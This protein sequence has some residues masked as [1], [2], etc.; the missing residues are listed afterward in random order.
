VKVLYVLGNYPKISETYV[1][2]EITFMLQRGVD[3]EVWSKREGTPGMEAQVP[4]HR[5]A[6]LSALRE[7]KPDLVHVHYLI[8]GDAEILAA[9]AEGV[10]VTIRG[11]SY[12][13]T[14][15]NVR[16]RLKC[17][18][19]QRIYLFPHFCTLF[20][21]DRRVMP[22]PVAYDGDRYSFLPPSQKDHH[23]VLRTCAAKPTKGIAD[24]L[25]VSALCPE[26]RFVLLANT[27]GDGWV[28]TL[29]EMVKTIGRVELRED[30]PNEVA[31]MWT[32]RAGIYLDTNDPKGHSFGMPISVVESMATGAAVL[33][34]GS[35]E[36][37]DYVMSGGFLYWNIEEAA[38]RIRET[39]SWTSDQWKETGRRAFDRAQAFAA[40]NV[41]PAVLEDWEGLCRT[42]SP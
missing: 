32:R 28:V 31:A 21:G 30:V 42:P 27:V 35:R 14:P 12:D 26:F 3:V 11:H 34:R 9:G 6:F 22:L 16:K 10:P 20:Q 8:V 2:A 4:V 41:L 17:P 1:S 7:T 33:I 36:A 19:V 13:F 24:F 25:K 38:A 37:S 15:D 5:G 23:V 40:K 39:A 18:Y 29:R